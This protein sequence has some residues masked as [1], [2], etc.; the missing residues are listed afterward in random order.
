V[1]SI[2]LAKKFALFEDT[3]SPKI[4]GAFNENYVK[5]VRIDGEFIWHHHERE[6]EL[7]V[8]LDGRLTMQFRDGDVP[9]GPG[10]IIIVPRG[11]EHRPVTDRPVRIMLIEPK[12]VVNTGNVRE[13]RTVEDEEWI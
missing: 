8:V 13:E 5:L 12:S 9:V 10:E 7:F 1:Q 6:D 2:N 11:V 4:V 3:W